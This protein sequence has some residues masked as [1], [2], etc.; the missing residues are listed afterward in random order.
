MTGASAPGTPEEE[1]SLFDPV[2]RDR[3][4]PSV[5][6]LIIR[7][8]RLLVTVNSDRSGPFQLLPGGGQEF[9]ESLVEALRRECR[10]EISLEV[11]VGDLVAVRDYI[12]AHHEFA[13]WDSHYHQ[14]ELIF[15][16]SI[17][18]DAEPR[19]GPGSDTFQ[20][21]VRWLPL[22]DVDAAP[23]YPAALKAWL[24]L[25][26]ERRPIYLGDVN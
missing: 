11:E 25:A 8:D 12:G 16:A 5:K 6:A 23:L 3:V 19:V 17:A 10:E 21:G 9:G 22:A 14:I 24:R 15:E 18:A 13:A 1:P 26:A 7:D 20:T 2:N 4:R